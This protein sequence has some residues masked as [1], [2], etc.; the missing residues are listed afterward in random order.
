M[1]WLPA[2]TIR[3]GRRNRVV[4]ERHAT[5]DAYEFRRRRAEWV[6]KAVTGSLARVK[7]IQR[8]GLLH[9]L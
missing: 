7:Q 8:C 3:V 6:T 4:D 5:G 9:D 1:T 2:R